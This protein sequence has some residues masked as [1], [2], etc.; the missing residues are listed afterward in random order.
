MA[1]RAVNCRELDGIKRRFM[2]HARAQLCHRPRETSCGK[3]G[4]PLNIPL[5]AHKS[6]L[7]NQYPYGLKL[8]KKHY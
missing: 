7:S 8:K 3:N 1:Q 6:K 2:A 5:D 4:I